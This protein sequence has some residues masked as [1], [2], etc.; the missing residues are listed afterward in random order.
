MLKKFVLIILIGVMVGSVGC[1]KPKSPPPAE[2]NN[3]I[4]ESVYFLVKDGKTDYVIVKP[5]KQDAY[6]DEAVSELKLFF[7]MATGI[8]LTVSSE[9]EVAFSK[10]KPF[11]VLGE[12]QFLRQENISYDKAELKTSGYRIVTSDRSVF[13][14][15][16]TG[17]G[18]LYAVYEFLEWQFG[19]RYYAVDEI[20][21]QTDVADRKL[22]QFDIKNIPDFD[23]RHPSSFEGSSNV[24]VAHRLKSQVV[25]DMFINGD[26]GHNAS[27]FVPDDALSDWLSG[28]QLCY[29]RDPEALAD[30]VFPEMKKRILED[31]E[32]DILFFGMADG[33]TW[34]ACSSCTESRR[35]YGADSASVIIFLNICARKIDAWMHADISE[36]SYQKAYTEKYGK[37]PERDR[38][39]IISTFAYLRT[40]APPVTVNQTT[41]EYEATDPKVIC[42]K[43]VA[44]WFAPIDAQFYYDFDHPKNTVNALYQKQW[45]AIC[46][47]VD[48]YYYGAYHINGE[49]TPYNQYNAQQKN[50]QFALENKATLMYELQGLHKMS[51]DFYRLKMYLSSRL[52]WD[53]HIDYEQAINDYFNAYYKDAA[54]YMKRFFDEERYWYEVIA[55]TSKQNLFVDHGSVMANAKYW[56]EH[57][58]EDWLNTIDLAFESIET[59]KKSDY[60]LYEKLYK[61]ILAET[62]SIRWLQLKCYKPSID[63]FDAKVAQLIVDCESLGMVSWDNKCIVTADSF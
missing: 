19:Y 39:I 25:A 54:P 15:G 1:N 38:E 62:V 20:V 11:L 13:M 33:D 60:S 51:S 41:G 63:D 43:N 35:K 6:I 50:Y 18:T 45:A 31:T 30:V 48:A 34:C 24:Q 23:M 57:M 49:L 47:R 32:R 37:A 9:S 29:S 10:D 61:R 56:P 14:V 53:V 59:Y 26:A 16:G 55:S 42:D 52:S 8:E 3:S 21:I 7:S 27:D 5:D 22:M 46:N 36:D 44:I 4:T 28:I 58:L 17:L 40:Q 12:T 2:E